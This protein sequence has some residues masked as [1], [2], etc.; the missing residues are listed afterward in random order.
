KNVPNT[1]WQSRRGNRPRTNRDYTRACIH[2]TTGNPKCLCRCAHMILA[3][4]RADSN[5]FRHNK[6]LAVGSPQQ[7]LSFGI[8][9]NGFGLRVKAQTAA[10][11]IGN[12]SQVAK[13]RTLVAFFNVGVRQV[14]ILDAVE[15]IAQMRPFHLSGLVRS[16]DAVDDVPA[17]LVKS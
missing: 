16:A 12:V 11:T 4:C 10:H 9:G 1:A 14:M 2:V 6:R 3:Y 17:L 8:A 13:P 5:P 7:L 15:E